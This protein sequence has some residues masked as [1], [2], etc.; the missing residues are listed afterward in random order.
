MRQ[1]IYILF[2]FVLLTSCSEYQKVL[3]QK[4]IKPKFDLANRFYEE[5]LKE[6]KNRKLTRAIKLYEQIL[7]T[8]QGKPQAEII[9][10]NTANAY[11]T[12]GDYLLSGYKFERFTKAYPTSQKAEEAVFKSAESY[13]HESP[14]YSLD[15]IDTKKAINKLQL[16]INEYPDGQYFDEANEKLQE[17][18]FKLEKKYYEIAKQ[19]HHTYRYKAA[20]SDFN[21]YLVKYPG[22]AFKEQT[23][24]YRFES[25]YLLAINSFI[26]LMKDRLETALSYFEDYKER[27]PEGE[28]LDQAQDYANDINLRIKKMETNNTEQQ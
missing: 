14:R 22:S 13:Y 18:R 17:L 16:Y 8:L 2:A 10:F 21:N 7:P 26:N 20:I 9:Q 24:F 19:Y 28:F 23:Y 12:V 5:G 4:D 11:Y 15:Q 25:A 27:Y 3:K 1:L 6:N